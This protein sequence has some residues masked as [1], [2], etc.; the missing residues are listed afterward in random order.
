M[1]GVCL[2]V[3]NT[4]VRPS[5]ASVSISYITKYVWEPTYPFRGVRL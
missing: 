3:A 1:S 4:W 5:D 2:M